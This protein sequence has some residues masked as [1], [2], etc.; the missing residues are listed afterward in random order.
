MAVKVNTLRA[1]PIIISQELIGEVIRSSY[2][3]SFFSSARRRIVS[4]GT[5]KRLTVFISEK[6]EEKSLELF[7]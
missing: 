3:P 4:I 2:V 1:F 6:K 5:M 7:T